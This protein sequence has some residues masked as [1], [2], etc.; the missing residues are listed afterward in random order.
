MIEKTTMQLVLEYFFTFPSQQIHFRELS[1]KMRLS[2]PA[3]IAALKKLESEKLVNITRGK[4]LTTVKTNGDSKQFIQLKRVYNLE[5]LYLSGI[6]DKLSRAL[7]TPAAIVCFGSYSRGEDT[8]T[9]DIDIA[10]MGGNEKSISLNEFE[11]RLNRSLSLHQV[12]MGKISP[13]FRANLYNGIVLE[14]AL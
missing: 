14:G 2:M 7:G 5:Q 10:V 9:S 11:K 12:T 13:E 1:R 6:V 8:E 4:A 3:I